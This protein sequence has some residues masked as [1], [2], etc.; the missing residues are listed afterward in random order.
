M[1]ISGVV[2]KSILQDTATQNPKSGYSSFKI[3]RDMHQL[4]LETAIQEPGIHVV[5]GERAL[6]NTFFAKLIRLDPDLIVSH[7]LFSSILEILYSRIQALKISNWSRLGRMIRTRL[8]AFRKDQAQ[9]NWVH[10]LR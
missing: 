4:H 7:E 9:S 10:N 8:P 1:A 3:I 6:I 5:T 2:H